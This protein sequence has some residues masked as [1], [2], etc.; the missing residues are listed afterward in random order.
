MFRFLRCLVPLALLPLGCVSSLHAQ[1]TLTTAT[2]TGRVVDPS[3]S[4]V[5]H[6]S[7]QG[8]ALATNQTHETQTDNQG[9]FRLPFVLIGSSAERF[10]GSRSSRCVSASWLRTALSISESCRETA[11]AS[12]IKRWLL[13][14]NL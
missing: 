10:E 13:L 1:E 3:G 6:A 2:V 11:V 7:V 9:R 12:S 5:P 4:V 8:L 14:A